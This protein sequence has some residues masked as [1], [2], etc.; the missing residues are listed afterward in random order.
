MSLM[1]RA[2]ISTNVIVAGVLGVVLL[3]VADSPIISP[4]LLDDVA[5]VGSGYTNFQRPSCMSII[6]IL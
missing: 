3:V 5:A 6:L 4:V 2:A 1:T